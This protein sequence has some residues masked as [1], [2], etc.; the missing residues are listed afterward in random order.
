MNDRMRGISIPVPGIGGKQQ[1]SFDLKEAEHKI[2]ESCQ[3]EIFEKLYR[4]GM[5]SQFAS[6]NKTKMDITVEYPVY[7]CRDCGWEF[8]TEVRA[9]Q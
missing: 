3:S 8:G 9:K 1:P 5:I 2:C 4:L 6:G 7:V